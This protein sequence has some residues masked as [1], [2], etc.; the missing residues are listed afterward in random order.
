[1]S[2]PLQI[3]ITGGIGAGKSI[4]CRVFHCLGTP[5]YDADSRAKNLINTDSVLRQHIVYHF[6]E[7]A[8][9]NSGNVNREYL[10]TTVFADK[11]KTAMLNKL[12]HPRVGVDYENWLNQN[13]NAAYVI[14]EA[15]L[16]IES[17]SYQTLDYLITV[18]A[19]VEER[20]KRV[21]LRD[22][23][24]E[25]QQIKDIINL[26]LSEEEKIKKSDYIIVNDN[27]Q[28]AVPLALQLH[29]LFSTSSQE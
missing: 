6:G 22:P 8:Y 13:K 24:R 16:L 11:Q 14:K 28:L 26:Q 18:T 7:Q 25:E 19:P 10:A 20:I 27:R 5:V 23:H 1:M 21:K 29:K 15:A 3:G 12:V 9:L 2:K 4:I 17:G